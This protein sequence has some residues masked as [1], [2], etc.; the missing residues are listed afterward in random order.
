MCVRIR[1]ERER[2]TGRGGGT[3]DEDAEVLR[4]WL[5]AYRTVL[6]HKTTHMHIKQK[7]EDAPRAATAA[8]HGKTRKRS[9]CF[10]LLMFAWFHDMV[11]RQVT[12]LN[13]KA[14]EAT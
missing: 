1:E 10:S 4:P 8:T 2:E 13:E 14:A 11:R 6:S 9:F 12:G 3:S 5:G 7:T